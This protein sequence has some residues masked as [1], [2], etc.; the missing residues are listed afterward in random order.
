M[1]GRL[2]R[3]PGHARF[4]VAVRRLAA[5]RLAIVTVAV[6]ASGC[7]TSSQLAPTQPSAITQQLVIRSLERALAQL[8][9]T[10]LKDRKVSLDLFA[11][12]ASAQAF[13][14][15]FVTAWLEAHGTQVAFTAQ[16]LKLRIFVPVLGT[17]RGETFFGIPTILVPVIGI[18]SPEISLFKWVR[19]RGLAEV[20]IYVF[21]ATTNTFVDTVGPGVGRAKQDDF[22]L[23]IIIN[24]TLTDADERARADHTDSDRR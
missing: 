23:L 10:R 17:D 6:L 18:P 9:A 4:R 2:A 5:H 12:Q 19:N 13:A 14:K 1:V 7:A 20:S 3:S 8:D 16:D 15:E 24:F 11:Q 22:T 21:D